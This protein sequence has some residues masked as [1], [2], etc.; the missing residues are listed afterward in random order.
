VPDE[1]T[2]AREGRARRRQPLPRRRAVAELVAGGLF[3]AAAVALAVLADADREFEAGPTIVLVAL[4]A[5]GVRVRIDTGI[6]YTTP[7]QLAFVPMLLLLPTPFVPLL[8]LL[9]WTIGRLPDVL[10]RDG[11]HPDRLLLLPGDSWFSFGPALVLVVADAQLPDPAKWPVYLL[12]LAAQF[13]FEGLSIYLREWGGRGA[14]PE[15]DAREF[16]LVSGIDAL[17]A[18]LGLLAVFAADEFEYAFLLLVPPAA[19]L[20][21]YARERTGRIDN[22]VALA[23]AAR[24]RQ[25]LIAGASHEMVTPL[26]VL[27]GLSGR[28]TSGRELPPERRAEIDAVMRREIIALR[29]I[30]RQFV[31]YTRLKTE[32]DLQ[33]RAEPVEL[34]RVAEDVAAG[35][36]SSGTVTVEAPGTVPPALV[37]PH[38]AHQMVTAIAMEALEG[39]DAIKLTVR[40]AGDGVTTTATSPH[41]LRERPFTEGGEGAAGGLG[42][43]VTREVARLHGGDLSAEATPDGGARYVLTLPS[44]R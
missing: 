31:D 5:A 20:G 21:F 34:T 28:L 3:V 43:Y 36:A 39:A 38:R 17:L 22:A 10:L 33:L 6:T 8:V 44:A 15:F 41:P 12:A 29:Q 30:I 16:A 9:A 11:T 25:E 14:A 24:D 18:P 7:V 19:L 32:R 4:F 1:A 42:L 13:A 35:L 37:D 26:G 40:G 27:V 2:L 23:D